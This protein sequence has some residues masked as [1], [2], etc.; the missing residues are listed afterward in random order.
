MTPFASLM[1][2]ANGLKGRVDLPFATLASL[3]V[4]ENPLPVGVVVGVTSPDVDMS[5]PR[6]TPLS[7][8]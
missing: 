2:V 8:I 3:A 1:R 5:P 6:E 4:I 7:G